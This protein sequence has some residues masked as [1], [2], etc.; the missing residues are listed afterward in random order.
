VLEGKRETL[1]LNFIMLTN[2]TKALHEPYSTR[3]VSSNQK[4][5]TRHACSRGQSASLLS[6]LT[7]RVSPVATCLP[8]CASQKP[9]GKP[10]RTGV[11]Q[12]EHHREHHRR[13]IQQ[14]ECHQ[15][16]DTHQDG[17]GSQ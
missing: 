6:G 12:N 14:E 3:P 15:Q 5:I 17:N 10:D 11:E 13:G 2:V 16:P 4:S 7:T 8:G 1:S 9:T